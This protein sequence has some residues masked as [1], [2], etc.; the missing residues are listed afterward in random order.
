MIYEVMSHLM[1]AKS[2]M[3]PIKMAVKIKIQDGGHDE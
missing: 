2:K 1:A 3:T